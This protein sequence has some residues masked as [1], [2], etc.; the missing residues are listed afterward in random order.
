M[1]ALFC[2]VTLGSSCVGKVSYSAET[3]AGH[4]RVGGKS[5]ESSRL[6]GR[7]TGKQE[8]GQLLFLIYESRDMIK[9]W[10]S[11]ARRVNA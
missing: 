3:W 10:W 2:Q 11:P 9:I 6:F 1:W 7:Q 8:A 5:L 4:R